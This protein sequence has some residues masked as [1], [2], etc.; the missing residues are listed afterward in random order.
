MNKDE[1]I[2]FAAS[3]K[4]LYP[5]DKIL[6]SEE[7]M[8]LWYTLLQDI[9]YK[10]AMDGLGAWAKENQWSPTIAD[11]RRFGMPTFI[12]WQEAYK[13]ANAMASLYGRSR[14]SEAWKELGDTIWNAIPSWEQFCMTEASSYKEQLFK[15]AY[16]ESVK[17]SE[18]KYVRREAID[19]ISMSAL[20]G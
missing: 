7:S 14:P 5:K 3:M 18:Q 13:R 15:S 11:I 9:D 4:C 6:P 19:V 2:R 20:P 16:E 10:T 8:E 12:P 1:F 17:Q